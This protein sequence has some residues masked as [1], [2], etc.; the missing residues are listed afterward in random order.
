MR[1][2]LPARRDVER[3]PVAAA[4][5]QVRDTF[6]HEYRR[7]VICPREKKSTRRRVP[8]RTNSRLDRL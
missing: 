3:L 7:N 5:V 1:Y 6:R 2:T 8:S 4:P